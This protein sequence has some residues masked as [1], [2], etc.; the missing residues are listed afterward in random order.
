MSEFLSFFLFSLSYSIVLLS[1]LLFFSHSIF[2]DPLF[3]LL[4]ILCQVCHTYDQVL[5]SFLC[6][7]TSLFFPASPFLIYC[8]IYP[9]SEFLP[10][11]LFFLT[12]THIVLL[13]TFI[14]SHSI[15]RDPLFSL[16]NTLYHG[17]ITHMTRFSI[18]FMFTYSLFFLLL[19][20]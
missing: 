14:F 6:V 5:N 12:H 4:N 17:Y 3:S 19:P 11:F 18:L 8:S 10:F 2:R 15:F 16:L 13:S 20:S 1:I 9:L 7:P